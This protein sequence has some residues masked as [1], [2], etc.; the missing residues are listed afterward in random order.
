MNASD[1]KRKRQVAL[2]WI[3][4]SFMASH[5]LCLAFPKRF[6]SWD[7]RFIDQLFIVRS[8]F[9]FLK[10]VHD[11][12][13]VHVD[14]NNS[15]I[16]QLNSFYLSR[17]HYAQVVRNL[18]AMGVAAQA[19]D[20]IFAAQ[21]DE[22]EDR[23]LIEAVRKAGNAYFGMAFDLREEASPPEDTGDIRDSEQSVD[24]TKW[25]ISATKVASQYLT[26]GKP[27]PTF[28][29]LSS[30]SRGLGFL[31]ISPDGDGVFRRV[32]L[33][34]RY[35][36]AFY[37]SLPFRVVCDYLGVSPGRIAIG[38]GRVITLKG[39]AQPG[40][41]PR[42]IV[43]PVD[44][45]GNMIINFVGPWGSMKHYNFAEI[46]NASGDR[47]EMEMWREELNGK[48]AL[49]SDVA[50]GTGDL[51]PTP[52]DVNL[53]L[54]ALH[55][56]V[57]HTILS[58]EFLRESSLPETALTEL[59]LIFVVVLLSLGASSLTFTLGTLS[60]AAGF[61]AGVASFFL[62]AN[63]I[64][65]VARPAAFMGLATIFVTAY[66]F[67]IEEKEKALYKMTFE[68]YFPPSIMRKI[69][70]NPARIASMSQKKE[71]TVLFSDIENFTMYSSLLTPVQIQRY[72]NEY[73]DAMVEIVFSHEGTVD[74]YIGDGLMVFFGDPDPQPDHALRC[75]R[76]AV[77]MQK[78]ARLLKEKWRKEDGIPVRIRIGI[79]T[80]EVVVGNMGSVRRLSYTVLGSA[81][82]LA[83]R[84]EA[85]A[86]AEGIMISQSTYELV[87]DHVLARPLGRIRVK[88]IE[89][90]VSVYEVL[91]E[92]DGA[93][94]IDE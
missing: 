76:A 46:Y 10:P 2:L 47:D 93:R 8:A 54:S 53:P 60:I 67:V 69:M 59:L 79:N 32:P 85:N 6:E 61:T 21:I 55:T 72:L 65:P 9:D 17:A 68:A 18:A 73:F 71:L 89:E 26:G 82:N 41:E 7:A 45:R 3:L 27:L 29:A 91:V 87:K 16:Q 24:N 84:L 81:V 64:V 34:V 36:D 19:Y 56:N 28:S 43:I 75:V 37:P 83:Q 15:A 51:G 38:P 33:L 4:F 25:K 50:T 90:E 57:I 49:I 63:V 58:G 12:S 78:K 74:K 35:S 39:A 77:D 66:R 44:E 1:L 48:L 11:K 13:V 23:E 42:D 22:K 80:G 30:A 70:A 52:V 5:L 62:F 94:I 20:I 14:I 88:G 92:Q 86:P 31:S 40:E